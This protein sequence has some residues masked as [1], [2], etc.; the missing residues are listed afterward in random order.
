[1]RARSAEVR[2]FHVIIE[3]HAGSYSAYV[4]DLPGCAAAGPT[5]RTVERRIAHAVRAHVN[6][7]L[8]AGEPLPAATPARHSG[9]CGAVLVNPMA[10][11]FE[12]ERR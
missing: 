1:M 7:L 12:A 6:E 10:V 11:R 3:G 5:T 8:R 9:R 2:R 4:P